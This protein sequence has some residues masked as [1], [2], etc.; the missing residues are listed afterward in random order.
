M[1]RQM[2]VW[3]GG[4][5][6]DNKKIEQLDQGPVVIDSK[7]RCHEVSEYYKIALIDLAAIRHY[8]KL[9]NETKFHG[10]KKI[11]EEGINLSQVIALRKSL[12]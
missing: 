3:I 2:L 7:L 11:L 12:E 8:A 4:F 9:Y 10:H 1:F 6:Y 5:S